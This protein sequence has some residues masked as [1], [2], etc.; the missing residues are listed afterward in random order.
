M[1]SL[2]QEVCSMGWPTWFGGSFLRDSGKGLKHFFAP[3]EVQG[4]RATTIETLSRLCCGG[5]EQEFLGVIC[6]L[7]L[8]RGRRCSIAVQG[9]L[10]D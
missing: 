10:R 5:A 9:A 4:G 8:A 6:R 2:E 3:R 1:P 7:S